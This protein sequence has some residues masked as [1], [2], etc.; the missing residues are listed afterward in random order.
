[1]KL[2]VQDFPVGRVVIHRQH[3]QAARIKLGFARRPGFLQPDFKF[4]GEP[5]YRTLALHAF[6]ADLAAH[7][8]DD[9]LGDR[10]AQ[11]SAA[12]LSRGR[13]IDLGERLEE[14]GHSFF[15]DADAAVADAKPE[16]GMGIGPVFQFGIDDDFAAL[17]EFQGVADEVKDDLAQAGGIAADQR[18]T[19]RPDATRQFDFLLF[20]ALAEHLH[21]AFDDLMEIKVG[22]VEFKL[23][24]LDFG[25]I[26]DVVDEFQQG[27]GR[28]LGDFTISLLLRVGFGGQQ[29]VHHSDDAIER[30]AQFVRHIGQKQAFGAA[31]FLGGGQGG[32]KLFG[33]LTDLIL[34]GIGESAQLPVALLKRDA[35]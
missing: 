17:G 5:E 18:G 4:S 27:S 7:H 35:H 15:G 10:Q 1:M 28:S 9:A 31:G 23:S 24:G 2:R 12:E 11:T 26:E 16:N 25:K 3:A 13:G 32:L 14:P 29:Q 21:D 22:G 6:D 34:Q 8:F 20:G 30:R 19:S 33:A